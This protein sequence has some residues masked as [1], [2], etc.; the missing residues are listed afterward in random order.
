MA[1]VVCWTFFPF[2]IQNFE[3]KINL[4]RLKMWIHS[5]RC[6]WCV[7]NVFLCVREKA[8]PTEA[9]F[10]WSSPQSWQTNRSRDMMT[11]TLMTC[12]WSRW[13][14]FEGEIEP[15][16]STKASVAHSSITFLSRGNRSFCGRESF[17]CLWPSIRP[18]C[19]RTWTMPSSLRSASATMATSSTTPAS[20][21]PPPPSSAE[22]CLMVGI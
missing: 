7:W 3:L 12:W 14:N 5:F 6:S 16:H 2:T 17:P 10:Y 4:H 19:C 18:R 1:D 20:L 11:S 22:Q 9:E 13:Q 8:W 21:W 15:K